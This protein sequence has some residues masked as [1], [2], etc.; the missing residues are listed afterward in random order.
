MVRYSQ[1]ITKHAKSIVALWVIFIVI[2]AFF[3]VKIPDYLKGD[4][5][6]VDAEHQAVMKELNK[7]FDVPADSILVVFNDVSDKKIKSTLDEL[8]KK[9]L[10][11]TPSFHL[12]KKKI[13]IL[14]TCR[15]Q[16]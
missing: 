5:F 8:K 11:L 13:N 9:S 12:S 14:K 2:S 16:F 7:N 15:M 4:G 10:K 3:A 1:F 6:K